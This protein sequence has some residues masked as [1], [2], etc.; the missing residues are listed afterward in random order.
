[1]DRLL[2]IQQRRRAGQESWLKEAQGLPAIA[3]CALA[4]MDDPRGAVEALEWGRA[5]LLG[6]ALENARRDLERLPERGRGDLLTRYRD[7][8]ARLLALQQEAQKAD[9]AVTPAISED[10]RAIRNAASAELDAAIE[11]IRRVPGYEDFFRAPSFARIAA[12]APPDAPLVY[13]AATS[14]GGLALVV[15][16]GPTGSPPAPEVVWL[17]GLTESVLRAAVYGPADTPALGGYLGA[18]AEWLAHHDDATALKGWE[19]GLD[20]LTRWLWDTV[21]A[22]V[23]ERLK[24]A[25]VDAA[26]LISTGLLGLLPL[27]AAWMEDSFAPGGRRYALDELR[28]TYAASA[29]ALASAQATAEDSHGDRLLLFVEP[30]PVSASDLRF[31]EDEA[32]A[33]CEIWKSG[34]T[35][36]WR[37]AATHEE[38]ER[39]LPKHDYFHFDGH[40]FAGWSQ[41]REGGLLLADD[42]I[43]SVGDLQELRLRLRLAV[44]SACETGVPGTELPDEVVGVPS[45]L[46]EAGAAGVVA[47]LWAV[48]DYTTAELMKEFYRLWRQEGME[49]TEALR[50]AQLALRRR[51]ELAARP[52]YWAAFTYT[53]A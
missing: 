24:L 45:A 12:A 21:M 28:F 27:H 19:T 6:E 22:P 10:R 11:A 2:A 43:L 5:R 23:L 41:A 46:V 44:L 52:H 48:N 18:Y 51:A 36:R 16:G 42:Q 1:M 25:G 29:R 50:Q 4:K 39:L 3:A 13:L 17:D 15:R 37:A 9:A 40:A 7:A 8:S 31:A 49:P 33:I 38:A 35:D 53:G 34:L 26:V 32:V 47:S 14:A 20:A 30:E